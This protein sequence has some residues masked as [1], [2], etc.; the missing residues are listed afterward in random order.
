MKTIFFFLVLLVSTSRTSASIASDLC[1][2][3]GSLEKIHFSSQILSKVDFQKDLKKPIKLLFNELGKCSHFKEIKNKMEF[4]FKDHTLDGS[5]VM[6]NNKLVSIWFD[7]PK[8]KNKEVGSL[9]KQLSLNNNI[10]SYYFIDENKIYKKNEEVRLF[11]ASS[12]KLNILKEF[13]KCIRLKRCSKNDIIKL[14]KGAKT[15]PSGILQNWPNESQILVSTVVNLM[16]SASDNTATDLL[17]LYLRERNMK[18]FKTMQQKFISLYSPQAKS[19]GPEDYKDVNLS[20][21]P[22]TGG[23]LG[24]TKNLCSTILKLKGEKSLSINQDGLRGK[25][26]EVLFKGGSRFGVF[27]KTYAWKLNNE[28]WKCL[29]VTINNPAG[30]NKDEVSKVIRGIIL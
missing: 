6:S 26:K 4:S 14:T 13:K 21:Y 22:A 19:F 12:N 30:I 10:S 15:S 8:I 5:F 9:L 17:I 29:S 2:S 18:S 20:A 25:F 3:N 23:S 7:S 24:T 1:K 27:Q 11:V 16:I 28:F